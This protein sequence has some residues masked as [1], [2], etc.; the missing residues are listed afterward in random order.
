MLSRLRAWFQ[1]LI[2]ELRSHKPGGAAENKTLLKREFETQIYT[3]LGFPGGADGEESVCNAGDLG[4][5]PG[6]GR[7]SGEGNGYPLQYS[8]LEKSHG[9]PWPWDCK[10]TRLSN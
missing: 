10:E 6:L 1:P 2:R 4:L 9:L 7:A 5:I 8:C 3:Q